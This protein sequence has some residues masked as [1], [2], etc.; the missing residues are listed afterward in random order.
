MLLKIGE[1]VIDIDPK[2]GK[3]KGVDKNYAPPTNKSKERYMGRAKVVEPELDN[4]TTHAI[5]SVSEARKFGIG[6]R[7]SQIHKLLKNKKLWVAG[8]GLGAAGIG[9]GAYRHYKKKDKKIVKKASV[10]RDMFKV[11]EG[12]AAK[13]S[14][15][16]KE[17]PL[18]LLKS[19]HRFENILSYI[20]RM[21]ELKG[22]KFPSQWYED[23][24]M[25]LENNPEL[26]AKLKD[27]GIDSPDK[28]ME[29]IAILENIAKRSK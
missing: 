29:F 6:K 24:F 2:S 12:G 7:E 4:S 16:G 14:H 9:Y 28:A 18:Q 20:E 13:W 22:T 5:Q 11:I 1:T 15:A 17:N 26:A 10:A 25:K 19:K 23:F 21:R 8:A 27:L 3:V